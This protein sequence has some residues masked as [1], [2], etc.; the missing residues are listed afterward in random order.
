MPNLKA[1]AEDL[2]AKQWKPLHR[3]AKYTVKTNTRQR[4]EN[5]KEQVIREREFK[6]IRLQSE[7]LA[8]FDYRPTACRKTYR[9][10]VVRKNLSMEKGDEVLFEEYR[11]FF[12][13]S[14]PCKGAG[15]QRVPIPPGN[16]VAP[17]GSYRSG[18]GGNKAVGAFEKRVA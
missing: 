4:P 10:V 6:N 8:R 15:F 17:A 16:W 7:Q 14:A 1:I 5:V 9:M 11:Y 18:G 13:I 12:Y 2:S 3:P